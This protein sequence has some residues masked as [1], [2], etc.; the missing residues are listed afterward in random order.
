M[1]DT[2]SKRHT[3]TRQTTMNLNTFFEEK[4]IPFQQ[5]E[6]EH[7]D[8]TH[9]LDNEFVIDLIKGTTG[10]EREG[11][12]K[13]LAQIDYHDGDVNHFLRHMAEGF[14]KTNY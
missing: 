13:I 12:K 9:I 7:N 10:S 6:I 8:E 11:I 4:Q 1:A 5:F 3:N 2:V 14:I